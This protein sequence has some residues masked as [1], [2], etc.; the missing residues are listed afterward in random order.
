M[1]K[2]ISFFMGFN[3]NNYQ[4]NIEEASLVSLEERQEKLFSWALSIL[5][6]LEK[7]TIIDK[8]KEEGS[9]SQFSELLKKAQ[10]EKIKEL[11][12]ILEIPTEFQA[13]L[14]SI[15]DFLKKVDDLI[16]EKKKLI[17][18]LK[19]YFFSTITL[20]LRLIYRN[21]IRFLFKNLSDCSGS[22]DNSVYQTGKQFIIILKEILYETK[23]R[24]N[25]SVEPC[26][27]FQ[28]E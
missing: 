19:Q 1:A 13:L 12:Q 15:K 3:T 2:G 6:P 20:D 17:K 23:N 28:N 8:V 22:N 16:A 24:F 4:L 5:V 27:Q 11:L 9:F 26:Y 18:Y 7:Q 21:I 14:V 10:E 25:Q